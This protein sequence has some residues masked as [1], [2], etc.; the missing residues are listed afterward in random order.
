[1]TKRQ[2]DETVRVH[3]GIK[4]GEVVTVYEKRGG[5]LVYHGKKGLGYQSHPLAGRRAA[6]ELIVVFGLSDSFSV[7]VGSMDSEY[8][9]T[10][11]AELKAKAAAEK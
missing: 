5:S 11:V 6:T 9:K 1:M 8:T 7:P 10:R 3:F 2:A 4:D